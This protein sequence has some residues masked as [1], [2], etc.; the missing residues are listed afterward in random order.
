[1]RFAASPDFNILIRIA[2]TKGEIITEFPAMTLADAIGSQNIQ[3]V[4][5]VGWLDE[6]FL[7]LQVNFDTWDNVAIVHVKFDGSEMSLLSPG[8]FSA[9]IYP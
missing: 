7:L 6:E 9:F 3:W 8:H 2:S 4:E 5:P 1:M